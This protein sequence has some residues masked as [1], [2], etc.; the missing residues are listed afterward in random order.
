MGDNVFYGCINLKNAV[1][2]AKAKTIGTLFW[3]CEKLEYVSFGEGI[4]MLGDTTICELNSLKRVSLP[5]TI[6]FI[7][8]YN[9]DYSYKLDNLEIIYNGTVAGWQAVEREYI[10]FLGKPILVHCIDGDCVDSPNKQQTIFK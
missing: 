10:I 1:I 8:R 4:E 2:N 3:G 5:S 9:F 6:K 7:N